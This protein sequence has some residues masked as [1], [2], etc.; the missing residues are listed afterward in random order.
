MI[1]VLLVYCKIWLN[2]SKDDCHFF[3]FLHLPMDDHHFA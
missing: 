2:L 3:A 1:K